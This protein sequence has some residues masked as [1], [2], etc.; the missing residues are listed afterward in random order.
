VKAGIAKSGIITSPLRVLLP[1]R[2]SRDVESVCFRR[3][4]DVTSGADPVAAARELE[5]LLPL[6]WQHDVTA[7]Q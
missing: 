2:A 6:P 5:Q 3:G 4:S 1:H 7:V